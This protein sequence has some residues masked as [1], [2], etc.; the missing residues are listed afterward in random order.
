MPPGVVGPWW[1]TSPSP[2]GYFHL[3][4]KYEFLGILLELLVFR[5][6][7]SWRSFFQQ[8]P[9]SSSEFSNNHQ[10]CKNGGNNIIIISKYEIYQ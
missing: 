1:L 5:N 4:A 6:M 7:V 3:L 10:T 9:Y 2:S 8:N